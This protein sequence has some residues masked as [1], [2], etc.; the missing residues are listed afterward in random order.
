MPETKVKK[1]SAKLTWDDGSYL[2]IDGEPN[3][4]IDKLTDAM[5]DGPDEN[6]D[7]SIHIS[8]PKES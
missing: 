3:G 7:C 6:K 2:E 1:I 8:N 5:V 4:V